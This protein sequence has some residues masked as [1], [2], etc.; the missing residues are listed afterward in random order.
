MAGKVSEWDR[1]YM[2]RLGRLQEESHAEQ[3]AAHLAVSGSERLRA[4]IEMALA[5]PYYER[6]KPDDPS[7]LYE[8]AR[9]LGLYTR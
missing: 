8:R 5:G 9:R 4:A 7:P 2:K 6:D 3:L 1:E